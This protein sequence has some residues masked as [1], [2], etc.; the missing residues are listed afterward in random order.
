M[1]AG[2][3]DPLTGVGRAGFFQQHLDE[4]DRAARAQLLDTAAMDLPP[5]ALER[6]WYAVVIVDVVGLRDINRKFGIA[7]GD[8]V[9]RQTAD[10][11]QSR[12]FGNVAV[13]RV[14]ADEFA[15]L[16]RPVARR[17]AGQ[18][19]RALRLQVLDGPIEFDQQLI[20][21]KYHLTARVGP[22]IGDCA[23]DA[24]WPEGANML[25]RLQRSAMQDATRVLHQRLRALES[26]FSETIG[27][28]FDE[29]LGL[30][31]RIRHL[32][33]VAYRDPLTNLQNRRAIRDRRDSLTDGYVLAFIDLDD[34]R[35]LNGADDEAWTNGDTALCGLAR[36]LTD[37]FGDNDVGRW[38]GDEYMVVV[39]DIAA[40]GAAV[41]R[42]ERVLA[43]CRS[44]LIVAGRPVTFSA[45][46]ASS[47]SHRPEAD[48][49]RV[50]H[51]ATKIA[52]RT[53]ATIVDGDTHRDA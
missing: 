3:R 33:R 31:N 29:T 2:D 16:V 36:L 11:L 37:E 32:E 30:R 1:S 20:E 45:G 24:D 9:L 19:C 4:C 14:G 22:V 34:L 25:W 18:L 26:A 42:L 13:A 48:A 38:G 8:A 44:E 7:A 17:G 46:V 52:K 28:G 41:E 40:T 5:D 51:R 21:V 50:A 39:P 49:L 43:R 15:V 10:R 47:G 35:A 27:V 53:K 6:G 23:L 12:T